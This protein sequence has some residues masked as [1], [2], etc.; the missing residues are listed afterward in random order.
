MKEKTQ[1]PYKTPKFPLRCD[2]C[3]RDEPLEYYRFVL[4]GI[5]LCDSCA[6][7]PPSAVVKC[8]RRKEDYAPEPGK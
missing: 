7:L 6:D 3:G 1:R 5:F 4:K 8:K 2:N